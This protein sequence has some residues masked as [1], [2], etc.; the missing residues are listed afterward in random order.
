MSGGAYAVLGIDRHANRGD[1]R[2][3]YRDLV[4]SI[5]P[6]SGGTG[7]PVRLAL[8]QAAYRDLQGVVPVVRRRDP[9]ARRVDV[10][11]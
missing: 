3:A 1:L 9:N 6:D 10:Y 4:R 11:A 8:V 5:H 2:R 7:D